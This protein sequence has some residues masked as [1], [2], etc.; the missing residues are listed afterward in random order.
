MIYYVFSLRAFGSSYTMIS[1]KQHLN[2]DK[3]IS[4][5]DQGA[6]WIWRHVRSNK[7]MLHAIRG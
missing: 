5:N 4:N 2:R 3:K 6:L 1:C 7:H